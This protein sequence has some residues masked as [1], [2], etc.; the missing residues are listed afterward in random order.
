[1]T[2]QF[3]YFIQLYDVLN[4]TTCL[5]L[6]WWLRHKESIR[7]AGELGSIPGVLRSPGGGHG[8]PLQYSCLKNP[9]RLQF[10]GL[11][12]VWS[13]T[14]NTLATW[15][16]LTHWK[17]PW[18]WERLKAGGDRD[19][20]GWWDGWMASPTQWTWVWVNSGSWWWTGRPGDQR[21][22]QEI[23]AQ[24]LRLGRENFK[25]GK[26]YP[27]QYSR[28]ETTWN[29]SSFR[30]DSLRQN[31]SVKD[32]QI[33]CSNQKLVCNL[34]VTKGENRGRNKLGVWD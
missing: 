17:R 28:K 6:P 30:S 11:Q 32:M 33:Y 26:K 24:D 20:R 5:G 10:M 14:T 12:R 4:R 27:I 19:D 31:G 18:C 21:S 23:T 3:R 15:W 29:K 2:H 22:R 9:G 7:S 8:N 25:P 1:M 13:W 34:W 16:E